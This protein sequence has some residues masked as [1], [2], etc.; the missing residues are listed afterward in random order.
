MEPE[1]LKRNCRVVVRQ[2]LNALALPKEDQLRFNG[3]GCVAC[4]FL[5][6]FDHA[7]L[8]CKTTLAA[9]LSLAQESILQDISRVIDGMSDADHQC[10]N[11]EVLDRP[12]WSQL[13]QLAQTA[14]DLF[15]W[16]LVANVGF[17]ETEPG[18]WKR[19]PLQP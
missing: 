5:I 9:D 18:V 11:T 7:R 4:D 2:A 16:Q 1:E 13:R 19:P 12:V 14:L 10:F 8:V 17:S 3:P 15:G 6:D